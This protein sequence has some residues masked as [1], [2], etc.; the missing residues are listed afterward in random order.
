MSWSKSGNI[1]ASFGEDVVLWV[2]KNQNT[3]TYEIKGI[4]SLAYNINGDILALGIKS[5]SSS[6]LRLYDV[7]NSSTLISTISYEYPD[8]TDEIRCI[9]WDPKNKYVAR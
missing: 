1:A 7:S 4:T 2:W 6:E 8:D 3:V 5:L 9:E